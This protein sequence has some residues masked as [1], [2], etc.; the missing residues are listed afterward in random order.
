LADTNRVEYHGTLWILEEMIE[1][2]IL[3]PSDAAAALRT[4][5]ASKRWLPR[6]EC[7]KL[8]KKWESEE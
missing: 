5:L 1:R 2:G 4:M 8:I 3:L 7:E 6:A